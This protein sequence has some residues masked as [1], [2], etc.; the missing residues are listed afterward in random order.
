MGQEGL[1]YPISEF[2][3]LFPHR[4]R[5]RSIHPRTCGGFLAGPQLAGTQRPMPAHRV[6]RL[7][8]N[9]PLRLSGGQTRCRVNGDKRSGEEMR[10]PPPPV[11]AP[12]GGPLHRLSSVAPAVALAAALVCGAGPVAV[13]P[14]A[15]ANPFERALPPLQGKPFAS[16][17]YAESQKL[18]LGLDKLGFV[19]VLFFSSSFWTFA[20]T[21][22]QWFDAA[23][24]LDTAIELDDAL[25]SAHDR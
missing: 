13:V 5:A 6:A 3:R 9:Q 24:T 1:I 19:T 7:G 18:L 25:P 20:Y 17:P 14:A 8:N 15:Q 2:N 16:T 11:S 22:D 4:Y 23:W 12:P 21:I 10:S